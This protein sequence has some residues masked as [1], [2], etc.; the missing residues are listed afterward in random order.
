M[1]ADALY[2][3]AD[4]A[5]AHAEALAGDAVDIRLARGRTIEGDIAAN[6]VLPRHEGRAF[7]RIEHQLGT[8]KPLAEVVV[9]IAFDFHGHALRG[10]G[11]K[12]LAG[13]AFEL[14]ANRVL[15]QALGAVAPSHLA[16]ED[17]AYDSVGILDRQHRLD[18]LAAFKR[19]SAQFQQGSVVKGLVQPVILRDLA[20]APDFGANLGLVQNRRQVDAGGL[21]QCNGLLGLE[22]VGA[23]DH[24]IDGAEAER[25]HDLAQ[26]LGDKAQEVD[27]VIG[28]AGEF[29]AQ[30]RVLGRHAHRTG[31]EVADPHHNAAHRN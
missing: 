3:G 15:G 24:F 19:R 6:D 8:R 9:G 5:V 4:A 16:A 7:G 13:D 2:Y 27:H 31:V 21:P 1:V 12:A 20:V 14:E 28:A 10:E 26:V 23:A 11:G 18:R 30:L 29:G 22:P 17:R 25:G